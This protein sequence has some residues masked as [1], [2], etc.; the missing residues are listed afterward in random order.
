[1]NWGAMRS[2]WQAILVGLA[3]LLVSV[4]APYASLN[5]MRGFR[6]VRFDR[7]LGDQTTCALMDMHVQLLTVYSSLLL[8]AVQ[9]LT[10]R[11]TARY[12]AVRWV[13]GG[14]A[15]L[16][17]IVLFTLGGTAAVPL[18]LYMKNCP[19]ALGVIPI[20]PLDSPLT[21]S[22]GLAALGG[23]ALAATQVIAGRTD[24]HK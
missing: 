8:V 2:N 3:T 4:A 1:M 12:E 5:A 11:T 19:W 14:T 6:D 13:A 7:A 10:L 22:R 24:E 21:W 15:G 16:V 18:E 23:V 9:A 20:P 17:F